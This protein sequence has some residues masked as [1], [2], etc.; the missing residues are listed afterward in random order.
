MR[1]Q[2]Y[3]SRSRIKALIAQRAILIHQ[4]CVYVPA[5]DISRFYPHLHIYLS[6]Y[7]S[8]FTFI[9]LY[10]R[11]FIAIYLF[12]YYYFLF[13]ILFFLNLITLL[14]WLGKKIKN[15]L[16]LH[17]NFLDPTFIFYFYLLQPRMHSVKYSAR[18]VHAAY[19]KKEKKI[20]GV[21]T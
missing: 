3:H 10:I 17:L 2:S 14:Y 12:I 19:Y 7:L 11:I 15:K 4:L 13:F 6:I 16:K 1:P 8:N 9:Y 18:G 5:N 20:C 21:S